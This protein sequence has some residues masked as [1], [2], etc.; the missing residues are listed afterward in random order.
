MHPRRYAW[1]LEAL[2]GQGRPMIAP[3]G[4]TFNSLR[5]SDGDVLAQGPAGSL[6]GVNV[7][8]DPNISVTANSSTN[9]DE[10]LRPQG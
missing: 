9:Q 6:G 10:V 8:V 4:P 7:Y 5:L 3:L 1:C 2:D